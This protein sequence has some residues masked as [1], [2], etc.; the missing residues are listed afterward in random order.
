MCIFWG[1][2]GEGLIEGLRESA[3]QVRRG[4]SAA[5]RHRAYD[6]TQGRFWPHEGL[7]GGLLHM[8]HGFK[9]HD[10]SIM[11]MVKSVD[12]KTLERL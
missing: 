11:L 4:G 7:P 12:S 3:L 10:D 1:G 9:Q 2:L 6:I 5:R 8:G